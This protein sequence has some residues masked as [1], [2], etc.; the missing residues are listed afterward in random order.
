[1][2]RNINAT[3]FNTF[4]ELNFKANPI[5][6]VTC[7]NFIKSCQ[8]ILVAFEQDVYSDMDNLDITRATNKHASEKLIK[9]AKRFQNGS[10]SFHEIIRNFTYQDIRG[11]A[12]LC[13]DAARDCSQLLFF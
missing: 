6:G 13:I 4:C 11:I 7:G 10:T 8:Q 5:D 9:P 2:P 1:M 12:T 3:R